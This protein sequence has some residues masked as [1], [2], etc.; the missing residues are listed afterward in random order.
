MRVVYEPGATVLHH[1]E[2][3]S[4]R[5]RSSTFPH[6]REQILNARMADRRRRIL[7]LEDRAPHRWLG[8]GYPRAHA[9]LDKLL[10]RKFFVTLYPLIV[11]DEEWSEAYT[12]ISREVEIV[13][14]H[15]PHLL[16]EFLSERRGYYETILVS[17]PHNMEVLFPILEKHPDWFDN[18]TVI[19]DA[20]AVFAMRDIA[21]RKL[22]GAP[23]TEGEANAA[24]K[25]EIKL[26]AAADLV[27]SVSEAERDTFAKNGIGRVEVL[28][29]AIRTQ[30]SPNAFEDREGFLFVGAIKETSPNSD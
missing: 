3:R 25:G 5:S 6:D 20:E 8:T 24:I 16:E 23:M 12:D 28:G 21:R 30:P 17:R 2:D 26:A 18:V 1:I 9:I 13:I 10:S 7:F 11:F 15:G 29:H 22:A 19:Y 27:I 14:E 4:A